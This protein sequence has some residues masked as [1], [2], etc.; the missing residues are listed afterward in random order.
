MRAGMSARV[1]RSLAVK[2]NA[3]LHSS[4]T[5]GSICQ[6]IKTKLSRTWAFLQST[7]ILVL[8][9]VTCLAFTRGILELQ[10]DNANY[11]TGA[12]VGLYCRLRLFLILARHSEQY[13][14]CG[15]GLVTPTHPMWNH[16]L[17]SGSLSA[18]SHPII[19]PNETRWQKQ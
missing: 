8:N 13:H 6:R 15:S 1:R 10:D 16:S 7:A 4:R 11:G 17:Q 5:F 14:F 3:A 19:S 2:P 12:E 18:L 9:F